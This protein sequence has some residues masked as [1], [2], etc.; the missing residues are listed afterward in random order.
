MATHSAPDSRSAS[1]GGG[2]G[3]HPALGEVAVKQR[4]R[5]QVEFAG[6]LLAGLAFESNRG[7]PPLTNC[8]VPIYILPHGLASRS[9]AVGQ[10]PAGGVRADYPTPLPV[11]L[12]PRGV[13]V[14]ESVGWAV[15]VVAPA[16]PHRRT[17]HSGFETYQS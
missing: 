17:H 11:I 13:G 2:I 6:D 1:V 16:E 10:P 3:I 7:R 12:R 14:V 5:R 9:L 4:L 15:D 8:H